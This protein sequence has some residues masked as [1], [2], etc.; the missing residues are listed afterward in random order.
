MSGCVHLAAFRRFSPSSVPQFSS[1]EGDRSLSSG[2]ACS[3]FLSVWLQN[4]FSI[5]RQPILISV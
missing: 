4:S 2:D 3:N 5:E 1:A